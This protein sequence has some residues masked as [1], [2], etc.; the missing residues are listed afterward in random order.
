VKADLPIK[1]VEVKE[2]KKYF[3]IRQG[4]FS[5]TVGVVKAVDGV[6]L[7]IY[8]GETFGLVGESGSGKSTLGRAVLRAIEPT[9]GSICFQVEKDKAV[10]L[11]AMDKK[12]LRFFRRHMQM[13]F[14]DP[15]ASLNPRMTVKEI[16]A[17]P[18]IATGAARQDEV[19]RLVIEVARQCRLNV[20]YLRRF[21]H[22]FSGGERQRIGIARALVLSPKFIVCDEPVS[23]LDVS[24]QAE[25][26]NLLSDLQQELNLTYLFISHDLSVVEH[27]SSRVAVMYLGKL[28]EMATT[29]ELFNNPL[30]PYTEALLSAIPV[31]DPAEA[32]RPVLLSGEI[33]S[34]LKPPSG[35]YFHPRCPYVQTIC[36]TEPPVWR[37]IG[38][39]HWVTCHL[40]NTLKLAGVRYRSGE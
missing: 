17:E 23:A 27:V 38:Q 20:D 28:V 3:L 37:E 1:L 31:A 14:Q 10:D 12:Q 9:S 34:P 25:I 4:L 7:E 32:M 33:P 29:L 26:L 24:I 36:R 6:S 2:L 22:A 35:C 30:H 8:A 15:Y 16:I 18:L 5:R 40:A 39:G 19:D 13:I 21:P 11:T